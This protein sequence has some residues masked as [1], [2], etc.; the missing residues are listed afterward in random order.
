MG[1]FLTTTRRALLCS[2]VIRPAVEWRWR[3]AM[4]YGTA[5]LPQPRDALLLSPWMDVAFSDPAVPTV[6]RIDPVLNVDHLRIAG[7]RYAGGDPL[8]TPLVKPRSR[9]ADRLAA[10][11]DLHR[12]P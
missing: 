10:V 9:A 5:D 7:I 4:H 8:D 2:L 11:D 3:Y 1:A 12:Y 6:A